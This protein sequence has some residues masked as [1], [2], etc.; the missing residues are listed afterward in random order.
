MPFT[1]FHFG[2][3]LLL[4]AIMPFLDP[5]SLFVGSVIPDIEGITALFILPNLGLPLHG[6]L[7]SFLGAI[8]LGVI[9]GGTCYLIL[10]YSGLHD[11]MN[12]T[13]PTS[14]TLKKSI[15]SA[16][17]GTFS[18]IILDAPLYEEM[19][20]FFP[21]TGN[22]YLGIIPSSDVYLIC[23]ISYILGGLI[24]LIK[25]IHNEQ[26]VEGFRQRSNKDKMTIIILIGVTSILIFIS[27]LFFLLLILF[28]IVIS[29]IS[30]SFFWKKEKLEP[31]K[32][33]LK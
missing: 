5:V 10:Q 3:A 27:Q 13:L 31:E 25:Y 7:H 6:P 14:I 30:L 22:P 17:L 32:V 24:M 28:I 16:L 33:N 4:F 23:I 15:I 2:I 19:N 21:F 12:K 29:Y 9:T 11:I 8:V 20:P 1:P 18:H 26:L